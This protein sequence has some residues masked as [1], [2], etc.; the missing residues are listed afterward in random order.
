M[1]QY[2]LLYNNFGAD[3]SLN[4][5][6]RNDK[7]KKIFVPRNQTLCDKSNMQKKLSNRLLRFLFVAREEAEQVFKIFIREIILKK[8]LKNIFHFFAFTY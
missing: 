3:Q 7:Q 6:T 8:F 1:T 2:F 5:D 4:P